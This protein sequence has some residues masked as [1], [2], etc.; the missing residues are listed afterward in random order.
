MCLAGYKPTEESRTKPKSISRNIN[1]SYPWPNFEPVTGQNKWPQRHAEAEVAGR[2]RGRLR[3]PP[4][5][6]FSFGFE[7]W[8]NLESEVA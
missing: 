1:R 2:W 7:E 3:N 4:I 8:P 6:S 5:P